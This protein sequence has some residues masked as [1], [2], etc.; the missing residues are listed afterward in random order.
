MKRT[1]YSLIDIDP[2]P[3]LIV[4]TVRIVHGWTFT[5]GAHVTDDFGNSVKV[6]NAQVIHFLRSGLE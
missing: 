4:A 5:N 2:T 1:T 6:D 3:T